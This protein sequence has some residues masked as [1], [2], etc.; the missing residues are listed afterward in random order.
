MGANHLEVILGEMGA[1][2]T[3]DQHVHARSEQVIYLLEG[4]LTVISKGI[5][6]TLGPGEIGFF[7][8]G[9]SHRIRCESG[10]A[11]FLVIFAP[12]KLE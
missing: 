7:P 11:R 9:L 2:G 12:P 5:Q 3:A 10:K 4:T 6:E 1:K 8:A